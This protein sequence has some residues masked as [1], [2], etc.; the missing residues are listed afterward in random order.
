MAA[1]SRRAD[2]KDLCPRRAGPQY[3]IK[4]SLTAAINRQTCDVT[5]ILRNATPTVNGWP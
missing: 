4:Y 1:P 5:G 3:S 2:E